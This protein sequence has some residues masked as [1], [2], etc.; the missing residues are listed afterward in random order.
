LRLARLASRPWVRPLFLAACLLAM[1]VQ[2]SV[3]AQRQ[4]RGLG[5]FGVSREFGR[6]FL[7]GEHLYEGGLKYPYLPSAGLVLAPLALLGPGAGMAL[8]YAIGVGSLW[9]TFA[10]LHRMAAPRGAAGSANGFVPAALTL[11]LASQYV[12]RDLDDGGPHLFLVA[13]LVGGIY[14]VWRG[15]YGPGAI[16]FGLATTL[17]VTPGLFLPFFLWKRQWRLAAYS[18]AAA[19]GWILLPAVWMGPTSWWSHQQ[20]WARSALGSVVGV[21]AEGVEANEERVQN[22][23]F[24]PALMR[25]LGSSPAGLP[26]RAE[27]AAS[28]PVPN[29]SPRR[30][31]D[32]AVVGMLGLVALFLWQTRRRYHGPDDPRWPQESSGVPVLALLLSPITWLQHM[33]LMLPALYLIV[34]D[35]CG[36]RRLAAPGATAI[37][38]YVILAVLLNREVVGKG[39][40]LWLLSLGIHTLAMLIV[41]GLLLLRRPRGAEA[42]PR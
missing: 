19:A 30:A 3:I 37:G 23:A 24:R 21:R 22:Q 16:C 38:M 5:D 33:V 11:I 2:G 39:M 1:V 6:R 12:L 15:R 29:L 20:E 26:L 17:K 13:I 35:A 8:L 34:A 32:L 28:R 25:Y 10:L 14:C 36:G 9:L 41:L 4:A 7:A 18:A 31:R 40:S 27:P 42:T